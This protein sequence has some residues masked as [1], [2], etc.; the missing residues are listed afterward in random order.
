MIVMPIVYSDDI[1]TSVAFYTRLGFELGFRHG[2]WAELRSPDGGML[3]LHAATEKPAGTVELCFHAP[4][5]LERITD[6][7][8]TIIDEAWGRQVTLRDP[9]GTELTVNEH[10]LELYT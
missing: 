6:D 7:P 2:G 4:E 3:A 10:D 5:P 8:L 9:D 1:D